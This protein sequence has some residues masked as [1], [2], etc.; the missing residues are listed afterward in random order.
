VN[1]STTGTNN[2]TVFLDPLLQQ[3][4]THIDSLEP[5]LRAAWI[6][7]KHLRI[8]ISHVFPS[9][10]AAASLP[11]LFHPALPDTV[12]KACRRC[13]FCSI[14]PLA[15]D[16]HDLSAEDLSL[17][18][19]KPC[20]RRITSFLASLSQSA[21]SPA[22]RPPPPEGV[23]AASLPDLPRPESY[24][25]FLSPRSIL[26]QKYSKSQNILA[27]SSQ[28]PP[29]PPPSLPRRRAPLS[30]ASID[31][32]TD[33]SALANGLSSCTAGAAWTTPYMLEASYQLV[34]PSLSNNVA[35]VAAVISALMF[36]RHQNLIVHTDSSYVL[37]LVHGGLTSLERA[38]WWNAGI[39]TNLLVYLLFSIRSHGAPLL[40]VKA[41]AHSTDAYNCHADSLAKSGRTSGPI[42]RLLNLVAPPGWVSPAPFLVG[43]PLAASTGLIART[44]S[45]S[46]LYRALT[47][48]FLLH[49][50]TCLRDRLGIRIEKS[51]YFSRLWTINVP[52]SLRDIL[53]RHAHNAIPLGAPFRGPDLGKTCRCGAVLSLPHMWQSC[54]AYDLLPLQDATNAH[55]ISL[56]PGAYSD[57]DCVEN[58]IGFWYPLVALQ[59]IETELYSGRHRKVFSKSRAAHEWTFGC[60]LWHVWKCRWAE[61][62]DPSFIFSPSST[63]TLINSFNDSPV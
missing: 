33:G 26:F 20:S 18:E 48:E 40:F 29:S 17:I 16:F 52:P 15:G 59:E 43:C 21:W 31:V 35:E 19:C 41:A 50:Y 8:D 22:L 11:S 37:G 60:Y 30:R 5:R 58:R 46:P 3:C 54:P 13:Q 38:G 51:R 62:Y 24:L 45:P 55:I 32:W 53:W 12:W 56:R 49:W 4:W 34:G 25:T 7:A 39:P 27:H 1:A 6:T 61:I 44:S 14:P 57:H 42:L 9:P 2:K 28:P 10:R 23:V 63:S 36:W 47:L